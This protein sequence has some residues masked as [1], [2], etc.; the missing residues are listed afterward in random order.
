MCDAFVTCQRVLWHHFCVNRLKRVRTI[1]PAVAT[2]S[3]LEQADAL[4]VRWFELD[5]KWNAS[6]SGPERFP[7]YHIAL[8]DTQTHCQTLQQC[9]SPL[10]RWSSSHSLHFPLFVYLDLTGFNAAQVQALEAEVQRIWNPSLLCRPSEF[11]GTYPSIQDAVQAQ[12]C[13]L[14]NLGGEWGLAGISVLATD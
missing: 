7:V 4:N 1:S 14:H 11:R 6:A 13:G 8:Y 2:S 10:L 12:G 9:L 3:C 5:V